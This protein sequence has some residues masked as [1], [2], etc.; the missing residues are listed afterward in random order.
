MVVC[1]AEYGTGMVG[2]RRMGRRTL[3]ALTAD[4]PLVKVLQPIIRRNR[5]HVLVATAA[6]QRDPAQWEAILSAV[7]FSKEKTA[8]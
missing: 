2:I 3:Y 6:L 7:D 1:P 5:G 8:E 4:P